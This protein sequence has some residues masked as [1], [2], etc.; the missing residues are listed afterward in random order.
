[1]ILTPPIPLFWPFWDIFTPLRPRIWE[2]GHP[3]HLK[4]HIRVRQP[5]ILT[6]YAVLGF[7][8][9]YSAHNWWYHDFNTSGLKSWYRQLW[10]E[11]L[12]INPKSAYNVS[13]P[14]YLTFICCLK[15]CR[16]PISKNLGSKGVKISQNDQV[17][18]SEGLKSWYRQLWTEYFIR[19]PKTAY[20]VSIPGY[21]ILIYHLMCCRWPIS[22][23]LGPKGVKISQNGQN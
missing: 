12:I 21:L 7:L 14:G 5:G 20:N 19:N 6:L 8:I 17:M 18:V 23:I 11:Y 15:C 9:K 4:L 16:W 13:I 22:Q 2:M 1:M 3:Q 10:T